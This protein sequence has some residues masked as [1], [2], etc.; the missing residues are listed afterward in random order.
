ME[1]HACLAVPRG[2]DLTIYVSAQIVDE[3]RTAIA[4][5]LQMDPQRIHIVS[6]RTSAADSA[7]SWASTPRRSWRRS[8]RALLKQPVKVVHDAA[9][10]LPAPR[11]ARR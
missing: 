1:P 2:D 10:D 4:S 7:R 8:P 11:R 3:A 9:A 5:T 6:R